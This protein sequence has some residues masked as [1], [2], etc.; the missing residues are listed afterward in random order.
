MSFATDIS[1]HLP[2]SV[3][4]AKKGRIDKTA[5]GVGEDVEQVLRSLTKFFLDIFI[6]LFCGLGDYFLLHAFFRKVM[7]LKGG[8]VLHMEGLSL[9]LFWS[10]GCKKIVRNMRIVFRV[11]RLFKKIVHI[12][13]V[14]RD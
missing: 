6:G 7:K 5:R 11:P 10:H 3:T 1:D 4:L 2:S 9:K 14:Y 13:I 12:L 8:P